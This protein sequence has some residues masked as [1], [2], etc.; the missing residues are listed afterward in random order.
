[1]GW[2]EGPAAEAADIRRLDNFYMDLVDESPDLRRLMEICVDVALDFARIQV[3]A[4]AETIGIG[5]AAA[6][7]VSAELYE[8]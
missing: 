4:G 6:S 5:D 3:A 1:M 2:V 8:A 7:Q